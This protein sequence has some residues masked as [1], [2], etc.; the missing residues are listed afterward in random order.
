MMFG[1]V[2]FKFVQIFRLSKELVYVSI[3]LYNVPILEPEMLL[4]LKS[5]KQGD[6]FLTLWSSLN[7][8]D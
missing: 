3:L 4:R 2:V 1:L 5:Q 7:G 8:V 6:K